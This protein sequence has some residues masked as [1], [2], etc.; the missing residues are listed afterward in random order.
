MSV[1]AALVFSRIADSR[2]FLGLIK[3]RLPEASRSAE[4]WTADV[5]AMHCL[6]VVENFQSSIRKEDSSDPP[7]V[8]AHWGEGRFTQ[9]THRS[10]VD[11]SS[12]QTREGSP[13]ALS[14]LFVMGF[15]D[16]APQSVT[17]PVAVMMSCLLLCAG[18][19]GPQP[20]LTMGQWALQSLTT[21]PLTITAAA[22][23]QLLLK[24]PRVLRVG[25]AAQGVR[26]C[27]GVVAACCRILTTL[28]ERRLQFG[29]SASESM[30]GDDDVL[31]SLEV[32]PCF[33]LLCLQAVITGRG[34]PLCKS[35]QQSLGRLFV[36]M[37]RLYVSIRSEEEEHGKV[38]QRGTANIDRCFRCVCRAIDIVLHDYEAGSPDGLRSV[39]FATVTPHSTIMQKL[40]E[41]GAGV[42]HGDLLET[43][44]AGANE[45]IDFEGA[46][47]GKLIGWLPCSADLPSLSGYPVV[48]DGGMFA[49][50]K[51][52]VV[53]RMYDYF[54][55]E[56]AILRCGVSLQQP[57]V[58]VTFFEA[59]KTSV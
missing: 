50:Q 33:C 6:L 16:K 44:E 39:L 55:K 25:T 29:T 59:G 35:A 28:F 31:Y 10:S 47:P 21:Y 42:L 19:L 40:Y 27:E 38:T 9:S 43:I 49:K 15:P 57:E 2:S 11:L 51:E 22:L 5:A 1:C 41:A 26:F 37:S 12:S 30:R 34:I 3:K 13:T 36:F 52:W 46:G 20:A 8:V 56:W 53:K 24:Y 14:E 58:P 48:A 23:M 4:W 54:R 45:Q 7:P 17:V 18:P 32:M